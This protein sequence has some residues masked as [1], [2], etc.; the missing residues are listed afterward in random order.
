MLTDLTLFDFRNY[1]EKL[2]EFNESNVVF[3]GK[4]GKGK[5]N[6]LEAI[7]ILSTGKSWR[8]TSK[9]DVIR[10]T[11][12]SAKIKGIFQN[13]V[14]EALLEERKR[15][16]LRNEKKISLKSH[17][18]NMPTILFCPEYLSLFS[19]K[20]QGRQ[21]FFDRFLSQISEMYRENLARANRAHKQK[22]KGLKLLYERAIDRET[23]MA[24]NRILA[25]TI[26]IIINERKQFLEAINPLFQ[27]EF[28][29]IS[30]STEPVFIEL[31]TAEN[32]ELSVPGILNWFEKNFE[33]E[34]AAQ[35]NFLSPFRDDFVFYLRD[36]K[37]SESASRGEERSV[38]LALLSAQKIFYSKKS[39]FHRFYFWMMFFPNL[40]C[41]GKKT[42][43][44]YA[45]A[46]R[47]SLPLRMKVIS[48]NSSSRFSV[49]LWSDIAKPVRHPHI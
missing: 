4:N 14:Y 16:F 38:L 25:E 28:S 20:K 37:I 45:K 32:F 46:R 6:I 49:V 43:R 24:W 41:A 30:E 40:T 10:N 42:F 3:F 33:R 12:S 47:F 44:I 8:E 48:K 23:I 29:Q 39:L 11:A 21:Q 19:G 1:H 7:S 26:P 31:Q 27:K 15:V 17:L 35:R 9:K 34:S 2:F 36:Q 22:T 5:T 13:N 18:G